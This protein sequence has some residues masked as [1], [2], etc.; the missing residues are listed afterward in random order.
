MKPPQESTSKI[1]LSLF[2][3]AIY[4]NNGPF[5]RRIRA[6]DIGERAFPHHPKSLSAPPNGRFPLPTPGFAGFTP[7]PGV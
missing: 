4:G 1:F 2:H 3:V 5:I 7:F 6:L